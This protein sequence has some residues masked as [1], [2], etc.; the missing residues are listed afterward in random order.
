[1]GCKVRYLSG[2][3]K[4]KP[5]GEGFYTALIAA[6]LLLCA[7][8]GTWKRL[9]LPLETLAQEVRSGEVTVIEAVKTFCT[10]VVMGQ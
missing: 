5:K 6:F 4:R 9:A 1:M 8:F 2:K 3:K 10:D 7:L